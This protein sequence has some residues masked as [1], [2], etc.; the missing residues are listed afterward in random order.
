MLLATSA[1]VSLI[2]IALIFEDQGLWQQHADFIFQDCQDK[3][4]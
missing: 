3:I 2:S 4:K 1:I